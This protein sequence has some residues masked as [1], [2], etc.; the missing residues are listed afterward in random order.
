[1][2][3]HRPVGQ[4]VAVRQ[5]NASN[6]V[7]FLDRALYYAVCKVVM[8]INQFLWQF[9]R[10]Y[11]RVMLFRRMMALFIVIDKFLFRLTFRLIRDR[12]PKFGNSD[13][14]QSTTA[15]GLVRELLEDMGSTYIKFGQ[16]L[17]IRPELPASFREELQ[18]LQ[19]RVPPF[20]YKE[21][22]I[23]IE[24]ELKTPIDEVF[25]SFDEVPIA[26]ASLCEVHKAVLRKEQTV[27]AVKVQRPNLQDMVKL[28]I[29][30]LRMVIGLLEKLFPVIKSYAVSQLLS[31]FSRSMKREMDFK[32]EAH[33]QVKTTKNFKYRDP[34]LPPLGKIII[35]RVYWKYT[36]ER[37]L[38]MEFIDAIPFSK[39]IEDAK[40]NKTN[41]QD[42][43][44]TLSRM[45]AEM[46][47]EHKFVHADPHPGNIYITEEGDFVLFDF[48]MVD[49][50]EDNVLQN[51][52]EL[53]AGMLYFADPKMTVDALLKLNIGDGKKLK[54]DVLISDMRMIFDKHMIPDDGEKGGIVKIKG[55]ASLS[56]D[57]IGVASHFGGFKVPDSVCW[58]IKIVAYMDGLARDL[59]LP[60]FDIIQMFQPY[61]E[62]VVIKQKLEGDTRVAGS[63]SDDD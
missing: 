57:A 38:T 48:G 8:H 16:M 15:V 13:S 11:R 34:S 36:K 27:V 1:M 29:R 22:K 54:R 37:V 20:G 21:A 10:T 45:Y 6:N 35:P 55:V 53:L 42:K 7:V 4:R 28:D 5:T 56:Q 43:A 24:A 25:S 61:L 39:L 62:R 46:I 17:S 63:V 31:V 33:S 18:K 14:S 23:I 9:S 12:L 40:V 50:I 19:E 51:I 52:Q 3:L 32:L 49:Y 58:L 2:Q 26:A 60:Q 59:E 30:I 47:L 44:V 41:Y